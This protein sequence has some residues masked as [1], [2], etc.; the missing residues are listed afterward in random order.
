MA[1]AIQEAVEALPRKMAK[2]FR[3]SL[4]A[5]KKRLESAAPLAWEELSGEE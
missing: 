4:P 3:R 5:A 1:G 2:H